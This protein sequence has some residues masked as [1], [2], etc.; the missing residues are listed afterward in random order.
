MWE[1]LERQQMKRLSRGRSA[2]RQ[3]T[4]PR[5]TLPPGID[6]IPQIRHIVVLMMEN[7]SYDNYLGMLRGRGDG[8]P[9][10]ADG[11][12]DV[13]NPDAEGQ[14][15]RAHHLTSTIQR[16][17][18]PSQSWHA[19]HHQWAEGANDG[20]VTSTQVVVPAAGNV[21]PAVCQGAGAAVGM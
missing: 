16:P 7:H 20:F 15:V 1:L 9:L 3:G 14:P 6:L 4:R 10:G 19:T 18:I 12:P 8:F 21:D 11:Q 2:A 13:C 5:P 17:Q